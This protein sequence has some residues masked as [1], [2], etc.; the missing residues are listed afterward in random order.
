[1]E[2]PDREANLKARRGPYLPPEVARPYR[3]SEIY[4]KG[5]TRSLPEDA[6]VL[7]DTSG[8]QTAGGM[9]TGMP[10]LYYRAHTE[11]TAHDLDDPD[12]PE[13]IYDYRDNHALV[14]LGVPGEP[15]AVHPL[16][17]PKRFY[18]MTRSMAFGFPKPR[19]VDSFVLISAGYDGL[20]GTADDICNFEW[21]YEE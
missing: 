12:N 4:G 18:M 21:K 9:R 7:C 20:Y 6:L 2:K 15:N 3:L 16:S 1:L 11:R 10:I 17:D 5:N 14:C 8:K 13:N 19:K